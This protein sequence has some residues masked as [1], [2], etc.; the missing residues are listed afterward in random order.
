MFVRDATSIHVRHHQVFSAHACD[1][2]KIR[3]RSIVHIRHLWT[4]MRGF[5]MHLH[6]NIFSLKE[7]KAFGKKKRKE[8][9]ST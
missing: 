1:L 2:L 6:I 8:K 3:H 7:D 9:R 5:S 4:E